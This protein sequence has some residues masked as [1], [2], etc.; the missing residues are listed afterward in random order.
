MCEISGSFFYNTICNAFNLKVA[1]VLFCTIPKDKHDHFNGN[2]QAMEYPV[3]SWHRE[4]KKVCMGETNCLQGKVGVT[5]GYDFIHKQKHYSYL[6]QHTTYLSEQ[7][8]RKV[9]LNSFQLN[10]PTHCIRVSSND[11]KTVTSYSVGLIL[12]VTNVQ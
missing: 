8:R 9:L 5:L 1:Q 2:V 6:V 12:R 4:E 3:S 10:G 11:K 7:C